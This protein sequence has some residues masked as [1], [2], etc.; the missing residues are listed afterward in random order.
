[1]KMTLYVTKFLYPLY[2]NINSVPIFKI[3]SISFF[4]KQHLIFTNLLKY[5]NENLIY[6]NCFHNEVIN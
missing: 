1:M 2:I 5:H 6:K 4:C 3:W